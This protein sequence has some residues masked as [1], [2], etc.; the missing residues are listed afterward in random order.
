MY[1][2]IDNRSRLDTMLIQ[3]HLSIYTHI[4]APEM[5]SPSVRTPH[6]HSGNISIINEDSG[7]VALQHRRGKNS[8]F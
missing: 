3:I 2:D 1:I 6:L 5:N 7:Q 8:F 4:K